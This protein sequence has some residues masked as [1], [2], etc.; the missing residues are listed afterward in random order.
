LDAD[1]ESTYIERFNWT[2]RN[3]VLNLYLFRSLDEVREIT[4]RWRVEYNEQ[5][6]HDALGGLPPCVYVTENAKHSTLEPSA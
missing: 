4:G 5:R 6:P 3:E 2:Y 1:G